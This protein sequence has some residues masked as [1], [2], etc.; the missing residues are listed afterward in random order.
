M[1]PWWLKTELSAE[2]ESRSCPLEVCWGRTRP[3]SLW[4]WC[5]GSAEHR[6]SNPPRSTALDQSD[7]NTIMH[8]FLCSWL[9]FFACVSHITQ[10]N[11]H[12]ISVRSHFHGTSVSSKRKP[13][14]VEVAIEV[15]QWRPHKL[16][17][18]FRPS[19]YVSIFWWSLQLII[20]FFAFSKWGNYGIL[21]HHGD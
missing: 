1:F 4:C 16:N 5:L 20:I 13:A 8:V 11:H 17:L 12:P 9:I 15:C 7:L 2:T 6:T 14:Q 10:Q 21:H 3:I 18:V 19:K